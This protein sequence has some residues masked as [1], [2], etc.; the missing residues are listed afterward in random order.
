MAPE[1][2]E[3]PREVD[4]RADIYSLGVVFY[5]MLTGE[6]PLGR[7][8]PPS[9]RVSMDVRLDEVVM[10]ALE[11][12][13]ERRYQHASQVKDDVETISRT[14]ATPPVLCPASPQTAPAD[15]VQKQVKGP[16]IGLV[17]TAIANWLLIPL[18]ILIELPAFAR[19]AHA[20]KTAGVPEMGLPIVALLIAPFLLCTILILAALRMMRL[21]NY[22]S[23]VGASI[24]AMLVT[25]GNIIGFP[26]GI[27]SLAVL[28]RQE[29]RQAFEARRGLNGAAKPRRVLGGLTV[30]WVLALGLLV[31][32][33]I[34]FPP[35]NRAIGLGLEAQ[36][37]EL[38]K[39]FGP[40]SDTPLSTSAKL[41]DGAW[42]ISVASSET[43]RLFEV[44]EPL[45]SGGQGRP[46]LTYRARMKSDDLQGRAYL[47]MW[48]RFEGEG[49]FFSRG[50]QNALMGPDNWAT[51]ETSFS[52]P[53]RK[54]PDL[55]R[56]NLVVEGKGTILIKDVELLKTQVGY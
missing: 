34:A 23:A 29:T 25:P 19:A 47:E 45:S 10:H 8:A 20:A 43:V 55:V 31:F 21:E 44:P 27:W 40:F 28:M 9:R 35:L 38:V 39:A 22:R 12:E 4:H 26:I 36:P 42:S 30:L 37:A 13:P 2:V 52:I 15:P 48:C 50:F 3:H 11:K 49:E 6:L 46:A 32:T 16:A 1:Q 53:S 51:V 56:L 24:V 54:R 17:V 5:E 41:A 33:L 18:V 14:P 7:F